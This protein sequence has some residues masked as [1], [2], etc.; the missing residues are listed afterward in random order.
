MHCRSAHRVVVF[1]PHRART[2]GTHG[3]VVGTGLV[4]GGVKHVHH[5]HTEVHPQ[6][7]DHK[8]AEA[9]EQR[10]AVA[11]GAACWRYRGKNVEVNSV[12][13][14][15]VIINGFSFPLKNKIYGQRTLV[16]FKPAAIEEK[17]SPC[18]HNFQGKMMV[19]V[20]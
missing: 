17:Y 1:G 16:L 11:G 12:C 7:V 4:A 18:C 6:G 20:I 19:D 14:N 9:G 5:G 3:A 8:E 13:L 15:V 10:Q 2:R